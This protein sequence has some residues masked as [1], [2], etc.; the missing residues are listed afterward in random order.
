M[1]DNGLAAYIEVKGFQKIVIF[2]DE[3]L[4]SLY[5]HFFDFID[6]S[7]KE[8]IVL[9]RGE[10]AKTLAVY[11]NVCMQ[12]LEK[13][14]GRKALIINWGGGSISD[15]GGFVASTYKRGCTMVNVPTTLLAMIDA[16]IGGKNALNVGGVKNA[17][18]TF[19][20]PDMVVT[21][22][23]FLKT[24]PQNEILNGFGELLKYA[25]IS[26]GEL[27]EE[28]KNSE[29]VSAKGIRKEWIDFCQNYK[30]SIV[31]RDFYDNGERHLLNFG[32]TVG[33]ALE[34]LFAPALS[35]GHAVALGC[36]I[37]AYISYNKNFISKK[38]FQ[39]IHGFVRK[40]Y[41][42]LSL[43]DEQIDAILRLCRNDKKNDGGSLK[44]ILLSK[45]GEAFET[46][47]SEVELRAALENVFG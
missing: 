9:P 8:F 1:M 4:L 16:A 23:S 47:V 30:E 24:L 31:K 45:I 21:E 46:D 25:L 42:F 32:H 13:N 3:N 36:V 43:N 34:S 10:A 37:A 2:T 22:P 7:K 27:W 14:I 20:L 28:L 11:E 5:P 12:L 44:F 15:F 18:G 6:N 29:S 39:E 40:H 26:N 35:H 17:A 41:S 38:V 33:H 19:Y